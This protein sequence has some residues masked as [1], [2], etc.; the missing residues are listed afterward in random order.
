MRY[1]F[2]GDEGSVRSVLTETVGESIRPYSQNLFA[3]AL[4]LVVK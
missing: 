1:L 3:N 4:P 2:P